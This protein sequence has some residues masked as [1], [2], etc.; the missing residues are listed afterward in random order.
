MAESYTVLVKKPSDVEVGQK[1]KLVGE[2][3]AKPLKALG[4]KN[5]EEIVTINGVGDG[6]VDLGF[7]TVRVPARVDGGIKNKL[8]RTA[9]KKAPARTVKVRRVSG[10]RRKTQRKH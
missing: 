8:Y 1:V 2:V 9:K 3:T 6:R 4:V 5:A 10:G 7:I